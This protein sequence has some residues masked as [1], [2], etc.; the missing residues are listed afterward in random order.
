MPSAN[1]WSQRTATGSS[2]G[3]G[4]SQRQVHVSGKD[5]IAAGSHG[6]HG[7]RARGQGVGEAAGITR[8]PGARR[9]ERRDDELDAPEQVVGRADVRVPEPLRTARQRFSKFLDPAYASSPTS[10]PAICSWLIALVPWEHMSKL[11]C[12]G[13][14]LKTLKCA[15]AR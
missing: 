8:H 2:V 5:R 11:T 9:H 4:S 6:V 13:V 14:R 15:S 10:C 3:T 12:E 1:A 7:D